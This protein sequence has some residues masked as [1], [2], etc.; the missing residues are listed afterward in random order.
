GSGSTVFGLTHSRAQAE[1][2]TAALRAQQPDPDLDIWTAQ[3]IAK[4]IHLAT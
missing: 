1:A 2:L 3:L 4:G